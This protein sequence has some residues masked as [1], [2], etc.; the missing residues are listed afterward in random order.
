MRIDL[1]TGG[2]LVGFPA[3]AEALK[4]AH[5][6]AHWTGA[7]SVSRTAHDCLSD[8]LEVFALVESNRDIVVSAPAHLSSTEYRA[9]LCRDLGHLQAALKSAADFFDSAARQVIDLQRETATRQAEQRSAT[10]ASGFG[11]VEPA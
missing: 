11:K 6:G 4:G 7:S 2:A 8:L 3:L 5:A 9:A 10:E 1:G